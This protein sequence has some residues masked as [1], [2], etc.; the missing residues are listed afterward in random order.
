MSFLRPAA[1]ASSLVTTIA[2]ITVAISQAP[3]S[4]AASNQEP[5][6]KQCTATTTGT[7]C[8]NDWNNGNLGS[9]VKAY[10]PAGNENFI[11]VGV[12]RCDCYSVT[13]TCP[14]TN[15]AFDKKYLGDPI[16]QIEY[17]PN[18]LCVATASSS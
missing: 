9:S 7:F 1:F 15:K 2:A 4:A 12:A 16:D 17:Q 11:F 13:S 18:G 6:G 8:L 10:A 3:T 5:A 14:F